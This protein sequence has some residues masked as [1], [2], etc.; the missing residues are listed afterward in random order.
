M[1]WLSDLIERIKWK[2]EDAVW[3]IKDKIELQKELKCIDKE[4]DNIEEV[5]VKP[6]RKKKKKK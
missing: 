1:N 5:E 2:I 4:W 3:T 6:K